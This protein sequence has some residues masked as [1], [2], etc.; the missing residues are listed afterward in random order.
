M[1]TVRGQIQ[2]AAIRFRS[3]KLHPRVFLACRILGLAF[4]LWFMWHLPSP[5]IA[6]AVLGTVA[7]IMTFQEGMSDWHRFWWIVVIT[8]LL[9]VEIKAIHK[10]DVNSE[11]IRSE[12]IRLETESFAKILKQE[13][14]H[15]D[16]DIRHFETLESA[17]AGEKS[18]TAELARLRPTR[19]PESLQT[20]GLTLS[21]DIYQWL[22]ER[23]RQAPQISGEEATRYQVESYN[24]FK[25]KFGPRL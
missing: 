3:I 25:A 7:A 24:V 21:R 23:M 13:Q 2:L 12:A 16:T 18:V 4:A 10:Q 8:L 6:V 14:T 17:N 1:S 15:F 5:G 19:K 11:H 9:V 22:S 20:Q